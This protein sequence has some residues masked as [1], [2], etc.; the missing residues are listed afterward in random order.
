MSGCYEERGLKDRGG[1]HPGS[2]HDVE[3]RGEGPPGLVK[4][5]R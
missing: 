5:S 1:D 2:D 3:L 4:K